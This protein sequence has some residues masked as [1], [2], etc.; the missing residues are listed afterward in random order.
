MIVKKILQI[1]QTTRWYNHQVKSIIH[2]KAAKQSSCHKKNVPIALT[3]TKET[4]YMHLHPKEIIIQ[5]Q[6]NI[7]PSPL[8]PDTPRNH[9]SW[10]MTHCN[11]PLIKDKHLPKSW[12]DPNIGVIH[13]L[14]SGVNDCISH[15]SKLCE[16]RYDSI[17]SKLDSKSDAPF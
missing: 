4:S 11:V 3:S 7:I 10:I 12:L 2:Q 8:T 14:L 13:P 6:P 17:V 16:T 9:Y 5:D 15:V 1:I